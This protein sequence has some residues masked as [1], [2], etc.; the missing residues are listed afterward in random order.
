MPALRERMLALL[1]V[2]LAAALPIQANTQSAPSLSALTVPAERLP[3]DCRLE[4]VMYDAA[5]ATSFVMNPGVRTNPWISTERR[6]ASSVRQVVDGQAGPT[7]GLTGPALRERL[8][9]DV[10]EA[11]RARYLAPEGRAVEVYAVRFHDATLALPASMTTLI[12]TPAPARP[13]IVRGAMAALVLQTWQRGVRPQATDS[14]DDEC[15]QVIE[16]HIA[17]YR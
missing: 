15:L 10:A 6:Y 2:G 9:D 16:A 5:G 14:A 17:S 1:S 4:P 12:A 3:T 11:Y 13:R 7:Y 8:A